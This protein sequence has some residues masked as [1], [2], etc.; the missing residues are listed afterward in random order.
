ML[1]ERVEEVAG[2]L[3]ERMAEAEERLDGAITY[4]AL[5]RYDAYGELS[6]HQSASLALLDAAAQRRRAVLDRAPRHRAAVLQAGRRRPRRA[7]ALARGGRGDPARARRRADDRGARGLMRAAYLGPAGDELARRARRHRPRRRAGRAADRARR[8]PRGPGRRGRAWAGPARE[9]ARGRGR[10]DARRARVRRAR[11]ADRRR[12]RAHGDATAS[13]PPSGSRRTR[14]ARSTRTRRRSASAP[15][16]CARSC[17]APRSWRSARPPTRCAPS[18]RAARSPATPRTRRSGRGTPPRL[19]GAAVLAEAIE[20]DADN[21][22]RFAWIAR[23]A[24]GAGAPAGGPGQ[25]DPRL[26]GRR[27][28]RPGLA[29]RLPGRVL[30]AR[31]Q[32]LADRVAAAP[33]RARPLHVLLRSR[34]RRGGAGRGRRDRRTGRPLRG[35]PGARVVR[36]RRSDATA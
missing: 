15:A 33:D 24:D 28:P 2:R 25:D 34:G 31:H 21:A 9:L 23:D 8:D 18:P 4:R 29:R 20:D 26:L 12:G 22:T 13:R 32:P 14:S 19:Y 16:S 36:A 17:R 30:L 27:R 7:S 11:R 3:E 10:V 5:V 35:G 6:G 1:H